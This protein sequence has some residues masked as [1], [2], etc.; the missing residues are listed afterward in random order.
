MLFY[1]KNIFLQLIAMDIFFLATAKI[2]TFTMDIVWESCLKLNL[3]QLSLPFCFYMLLSIIYSLLVIH[4]CMYIYLYFLNKIC[5]LK[6]ARILIVF[7]RHLSIYIG[8]VLSL[9][10]KPHGSYLQ[11]P[12]GTRL[13]PV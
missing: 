5:V 11:R 3:E 9:C 8:C 1:L 12:L 2:A 10:Q 6:L 7:A 13:I 4:I